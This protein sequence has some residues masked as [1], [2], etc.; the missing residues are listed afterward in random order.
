MEKREA[1]PEELHRT[2]QNANCPTYNFSDNLDRRIQY[3][4]EDNGITIYLISRNF[5]PNYRLLLES[6]LVYFKQKIIVMNLDK[7]SKWSDEE[8]ELGFWHEI[9]HIMN[10][11]GEERGADAYALDRMIELYGYIKAC[12]IYGMF[13]ERMYEYNRETSTWNEKSFKATDAYNH[14]IED[15]KELSNFL[16]EYSY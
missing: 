14:R 8:L 10:K 6:A 13:L 3:V 12:Q 1:T 15:L 5:C 7:I 16:K 11:S 9:G 4:C 2:Y